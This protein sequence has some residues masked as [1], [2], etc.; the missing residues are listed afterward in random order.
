MPGRA[1][2]RVL[3]RAL[4]AA[5]TRS[6]TQRADPAEGAEVAAVKEGSCS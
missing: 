2:R 5:T 1:L 3:R 4:E 6:S